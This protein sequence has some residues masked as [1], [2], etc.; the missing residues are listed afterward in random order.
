MEN[1][2]RRFKNK[3]F[4]WVIAKATVDANYCQAF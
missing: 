3:E 1:F 4:A 2:N